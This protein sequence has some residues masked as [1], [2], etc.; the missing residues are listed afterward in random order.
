MTG[1]RNPPALKYLM[2]LLWAPSP[3]LPS[4]RLITP[5]GRHFRSIPYFWRG[6]HHPIPRS[7]ASLPSPLDALPLLPP[8]TATLPSRS[9]H[10]AERG[11]AP[12]SSSHRS[13][14]GYDGYKSDVTALRKVE[15][16]TCD[17][18]HY[19][20]PPAIPSPSSLS[21]PSRVRFP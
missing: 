18:R 11:N 1:K 14:T 20:I 15:L 12:V 21:L 17:Q 8:N 3:L 2:T 16:T 19:A 13:I 7:G 5:Q 10:G 6:P 9:K 4:P